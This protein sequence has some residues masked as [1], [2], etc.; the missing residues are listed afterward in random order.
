MTELDGYFMED[1]RMM[2]EKEVSLQLKRDTDRLI[3][4]MNQR[5]EDLAGMAM[6]GLLFA[7]RLSVEENPDHRD[8]VQVE[9]VAKTAYRMAEAMVAI[10]NHRLMEQREKQDD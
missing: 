7:Y 10:S 9:A 2:L 5:V 4:Q 3:N 6:Q 8:G 1:E